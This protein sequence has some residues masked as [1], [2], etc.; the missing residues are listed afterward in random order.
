MRARGSTQRGGGAEIY[1]HT[2]VAILAE[3]LQDVFPLPESTCRKVKIPAQHLRPCAVRARFEPLEAG[4]RATWS[5]FRSLQPRSVRCYPG[6]WQPPGDVSLYRLSLSRHLPRLRSRPAFPVFLQGSA[7][8]ARG[9]GLEVQGKWNA[10]FPG[11]G[12]RPPTPRPRVEE[13]P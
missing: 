6:L 12:L 8:F 13:A 2:N 3:N 10:L 7:L 4:A 11:A 1:P 9:L 5:R